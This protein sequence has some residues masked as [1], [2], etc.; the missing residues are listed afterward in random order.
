MYILNNIVFIVA[1]LLISGLASSEEWQGT[2][3]IPKENMSFVT[4]D[5]ETSA[6][7]PVFK[8][9]TYEDEN[10]EF[11]GNEVKDDEII[12]TWSPG[13][14]EFTCIIELKVNGG[15][16]GDC[17]HEESKSSLTLTL[18]PPNKVISVEESAANEVEN[19]EAKTSLA[20]E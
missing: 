14:L 4:Y 13:D 20:E 11:S 16:A 10:F 18:R 17:K 3:K 8:S 6:D 2:L 7:I 1:G 15:Y 9:V 19:E 12:F 5:V